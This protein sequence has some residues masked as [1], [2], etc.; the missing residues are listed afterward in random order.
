M[1]T[2]KTSSLSVPGT[3]ISPFKS[4]LEYIKEENI[5][6]GD[7]H[8]VFG[9]RRGREY[10]VFQRNAGISRGASAVKLPHHFIA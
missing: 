2:R 5:E 8:L 10:F 7:I 1:T 6:T 3:G 9:T 4:I